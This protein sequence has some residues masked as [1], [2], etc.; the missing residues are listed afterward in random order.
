MY[1]AALDG[2]FRFIWREDKI[3]TVNMRIVAFEDNEDELR[4][5]DVL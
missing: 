5:R 2:G 1:S 3:Q 4:E